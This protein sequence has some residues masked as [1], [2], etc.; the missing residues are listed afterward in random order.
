M[1]GEMKPGISEKFTEWFIMKT[2]GRDPFSLLWED[3]KSNPYFIKYFEILDMEKAGSP[4]DC[5]NDPELKYQRYVILKC[6]ERIYWNRKLLKES[7]FPNSVR[8]YRI[9][10]K[11]NN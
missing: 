1:E 5:L 11:K 3:E 2:K 8:N 9:Q 7:E 10:L 4:E 6:M